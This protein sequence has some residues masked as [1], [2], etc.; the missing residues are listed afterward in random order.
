MIFR[1]F[2]ELRAPFGDAIVASVTQGSIMIFWMR[3]F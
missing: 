2:A 3:A 1:R